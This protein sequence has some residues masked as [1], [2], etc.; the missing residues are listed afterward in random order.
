MSEIYFTSD[1]HF[2]H[3]NIIAY[4]ER[5]WHSVEEMNSAL[6]KNWNKEVSKSDIVYHLGDIAFCSGD[7]LEA[8]LNSL[9]G[10]IIHIPRKPW[11]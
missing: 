2:Y 10:K 6:I 1:T 7:K 5:P 8:I 3:K 4:C 9:N 11:R